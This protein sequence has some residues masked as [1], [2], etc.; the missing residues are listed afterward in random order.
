MKITKDIN[1]GVVTLS[2][3]GK[4]DT[5][6]APQ[7]DKALGSELEHAENI[8]MDFSKLIYVTSA[9]LRVLLEGH[10]A[11]EAKGSSMK[12]KNVGNDVMEILEITGLT[13]VFSFEEG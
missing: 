7:L 5:I 11:A 2:L 4:L 12:L 13:G 10:K 9:G 1:N 6:T 8:A 3:E